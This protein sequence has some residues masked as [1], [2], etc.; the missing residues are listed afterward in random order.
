MKRNN[1]DRHEHANMVY[2]TQNSF[3]QPIKVYGAIDRAYQNVS[4]LEL[5]FDDSN[6]RKNYQIKTVREYP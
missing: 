2:L 4:T 1:F 6:K 5:L 3:N